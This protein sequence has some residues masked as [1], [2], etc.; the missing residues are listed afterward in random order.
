MIVVLLPKEKPDFADTLIYQ[1]A[2][3]SET[4]CIFSSISA[5]WT[6]EHT[7]TSNTPE[8]QCHTKNNTGDNKTFS[9]TLTKCIST[10]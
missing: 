4:Q 5:L 6:N 8:F 7:F 2:S 9:R 3:W 1:D 10:P